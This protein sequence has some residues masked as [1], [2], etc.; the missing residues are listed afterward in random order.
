MNKNLFIIFILA[1]FTL[2][3]CIKDEEDPENLKINKWTF[4]NMEYYYLWN[5]TINSDM[6][7]QGNEEPKTY[8]KSLLN[9]PEDKWSV[10][11]EDFET[12]NQGM[13]GN[14]TS[15]GYEPVYGK[16]K[17]TDNVY[18][19]VKFVYPGSPAHNA[20]LKKGDIILEVD[21]SVL[22]V[23]NYQNLFSQETYTVTLGEYNN[24]TVST[25]DIKLSMTAELLSI[26]PVI[27]D[28]VYSINGKNIGYLAITEFINDEVFSEKVGASLNKLK[29]YNIN[30]LIIDLRYNTGGDLN[31]AIWLGS[32]LAPITNTQNNDLFVQLVFNE[33]VQSAMEEEDIKH[34]FS[35]IPETNFGADNLYFLTTNYATA[36]ASEL[37]ICGLQPYMNV[38]QVGE[39]TVG[40]YHGMSVL[41]HPEKYW[42]LLPVTFKYANAENFSD[43]TDGLIP[44]VYIE[45]D[46]VAGYAFGDT[47]D[48]VI[49]TT[50]ELISGL[51][52]RKQVESASLNNFTVL[53]SNKQQL[54][55]NV[56]SK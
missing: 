30:D 49:A 25:S 56:F 34:P 18:A 36:S 22:T 24:G 55:M 8:F 17:D 32:A 44:D 11:I 45:D 4:A 50:L 6:K 15:M 3:S 54:K 1:G 48:P 51:P 14:P 5:S 28:T 20:G 26:N 41:P 46:L 19:I 42:A 9:K 13:A 47:D 39:N 21:N 38:T 31:S 2:F 52:A 43:F 16:F 40:K 10:M 29:A 23:D 33:T 7:P 35:Y 37:V 27:L 12:F 53:Y